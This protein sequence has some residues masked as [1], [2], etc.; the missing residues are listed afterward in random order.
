MPQYEAQ[1]D[2]A[3]VNGVGQVITC[4]SKSILHSPAVSSPPWPLYDNKHFTKKE[5]HLLAQ[6]NYWSRRGSLPAPKQ[7]STYFFQSYLPLKLA[8]LQQMSQ[9]QPR[10]LLL[11]DKPPLSFSLLVRPSALWQLPHCGSGE[12]SFITT[13]QKDPKANGSFVTPPADAAP[14]GASERSPQNRLDSAKFFFAKNTTGNSGH[15]LHG[16]AITQLSWQFFVCLF[17]A[18]PLLLS[19][20]CD[21]QCR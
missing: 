13:R 11:L 6:V 18:A 14:T 7:P 8:A 15:S 16:N 12:G 1:F 21:K 20:K 10:W 4:I 5:P 3:A 2:W 19:S 9:R 17:S